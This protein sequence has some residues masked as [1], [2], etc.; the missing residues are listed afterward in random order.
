MKT[1]A[2]FVD[3]VI[4]ASKEAEDI[5]PTILQDM[6]RSTVKEFASRTRILV[7]EYYFE[8]QCKVHDYQFDIPACH[9][10]VAAEVVAVGPSTDCGVALF[11]C[12]WRVLSAGQ[13]QTVYGYRGPDQ[14]DIDVHDPANK[15][16]I[17]KDIPASPHWVYVSYS[18]T[19]GRDDCQVPESFYEEWGQAILYGT[20]FRILKREGLNWASDYALYQSEIS[21][22]KSRKKH[23]YS[24][25]RVKAHTVSFLGRRRR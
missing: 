5:H 20:L 1:I 10:L 14:Y 25:K 8:T 11:D 12:D 17:L 15:A 2:D 13:D 3:L 23:H 18:W 19:I 9:Q 22:A 6:I 16:I 4:S 7:S 21:A 24:P